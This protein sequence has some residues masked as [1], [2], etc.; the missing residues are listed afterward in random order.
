MWALII[1]ASLAGLVALALVAKARRLRRLF[2]DDHH[3][4][5]A[6]RAP[7][8]KAAALDRAADP[9]SL[10]RVALDDPRLVLTT[11]GLAILYTVASE[12]GRF[13]HACSVSYQGGVTAHAIG[14]HFLGYLVLLLGLPLERLELSV[15]ASTAHHAEV[16]LGPDDHAAV[17]RAPVREVSPGQLSD[18]RQAIATAR[19]RLSELRQSQASAPLN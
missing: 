12:D 1:G 18:L 2:G 19:A 11:A 13:V 5:I 3:L 10:G 6:R 16:S 14:W 9:D 4:E 17:A 15:S 8:L 7:A